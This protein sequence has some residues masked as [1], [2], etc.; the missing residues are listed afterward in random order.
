M[1]KSTQEVMNQRTLG[2]GC[3]GHLGLTMTDAEYANVSATPYV[4]PV[5]PGPLNIPAITTQR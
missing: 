5:H 1:R 2:G 4:R 3:H